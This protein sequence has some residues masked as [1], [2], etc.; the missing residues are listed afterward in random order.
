MTHQLTVRDLTL[1]QVKSALLVD[2]P[3]EPADEI[4][5]L[6]PADK[7]RLFEKIVY[8]VRSGEMSPVPPLRVW[9]W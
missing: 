7:E 2:R 3:R 5:A 9:R 8:G 4:S 6:P 1:S